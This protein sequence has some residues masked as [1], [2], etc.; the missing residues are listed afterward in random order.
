MG[1]TPVTAMGFQLAESRAGLPLAR[2]SS[3]VRTV[4]SPTSMLRSCTEDRTDLATE[5]VSRV[6]LRL[7]SYMPVRKGLSPWR[8]VALMAECEVCP[9]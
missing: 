6:P 9:G 2:N 8:A 5:S 4:G 1:V 3:L 7:I